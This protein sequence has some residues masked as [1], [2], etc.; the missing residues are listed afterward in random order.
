MVLTFSDGIDINLGKIKGEKGDKGDDGQNGNDGVGISNVT[1]SS[2]GILTVKLTNGTNINLGSIKGADGIGIKAARV[3]ENGHLKLTYSDNTTADLGIVVG[4]KGADGVG[5]SDVN[6]LSDGTLTIEL[7][8]GTTKSLG[9]I[10]GDKGDPGADGQDGAQ[11][12]QGIQGT[13]GRGIQKTEIVNGEL[14][15]TY[16]DGTQ[17]NAGAVGNAEDNLELIFVELSDGTYG[18]KAGGKAKNLAV[19]NIPETYNGKAVTEIC[20]SGFMNMP[21]LETIIIPNSVTKI[22]DYAFYNCVKLNSVTMPQSLTT[23]GTYALSGCI[24]LKS[25][26]IPQNVIEIGKCAFWNDVSL[27]EVLFENSD[28]WGQIGSSSVVSPITIK[29][30]NKYRYTYKDDYSK[31]HKEIYVDIA[32]VLKGD[33][34]YSYY[35]DNRERRSLTLGLYSNTLQRS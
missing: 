6:I 2:D 4:A 27:A 24:T 7:S 17:E 11:G 32:N 19:I 33:Y 28:G 14:I 12:P 35:N 20:N 26:T 5:I 18:V 3:D 25:C 23:I 30:G 16:T 9:N 29:D 31:K 22:N 15:V 1:I 8:N 21:V 34:T 10:K 13:A